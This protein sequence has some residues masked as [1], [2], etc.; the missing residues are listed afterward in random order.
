MG[1]AGYNSALQLS[2][3]NAMRGQINALYLFMIAG[4]GGMLGP[5]LIALLTDFVAGNEDDLYLVLAG[6]RLALAPI[7]AFLIWLAIKPYG[8]AVQDREEAG[9]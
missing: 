2:T 6:F 1:G 4:V 7:D 8:K 5:T 3:P 9:D